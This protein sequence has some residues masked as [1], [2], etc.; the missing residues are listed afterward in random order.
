MLRTAES[1]ATTKVAEIEQVVAT[2]FAEAMPAFRAAV[3]D[4]GL[5]LLPA[6]SDK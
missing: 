2:F 6:A 5:G 4:S 3:A 1:R